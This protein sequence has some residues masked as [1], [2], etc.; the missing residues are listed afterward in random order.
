MLANGQETCL[1]F[2]G[3]E[4]G[5][6]PQ[7]L[8][9]WGQLQIP[10]NLLLTL[11]YKELLNELLAPSLSVQEPRVWRQACTLT[12]A[13]GE[14]RAVGRTSAW[15]DL[16]G[17]HVRPRPGASMQGRVQGQ[18]SE[19]RRTC[20]AANQIARS[21]LSLLGAGGKELL[22]TDMQAFRCSLVTSTLSFYSHRVLYGKF[23]QLDKTPCRTKQLYI[24]PK[25]TSVYSNT[26]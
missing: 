4:S 18:F 19:A 3:A 17:P 14:W 2:P 16:A 13:A 11:E 25:Y 24:S 21:L 15:E 9:V 1:L 8:P 20:S 26:G 5:P 7:R 23:E 6:D 12:P 22:V 10:V